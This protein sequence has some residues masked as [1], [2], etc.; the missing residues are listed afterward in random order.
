MLKKYSVLFGIIIS[1][2]LLLIATKL[3]PGGTLFDKNSIGFDW[4]KNYFSN[5]FQAKAINGADNPSRYWADAGMICQSLSFALFFFEFSKRIP[6]KSAANVIKYLGGGGTI[7]TFLIVTPLHDVMIDVSGTVF[8]VSIFYITVFV[9]KSRLVIF[10]F[11]CIA[12]LLIFYYTFFLYGTRNLILL[13]VM[14]KVTFISSVLLILGLEYFT[15]KEDF[16]HIKTAEIK[17]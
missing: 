16:E 5:L 9:F 14:Q 4:T 2:I 6:V 8:L 3:Y 12:C 10:K 7:F 11:A 17:G 15:K 13:P 1:V